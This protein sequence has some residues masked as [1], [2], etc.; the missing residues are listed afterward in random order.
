[1]TD[2]TILKAHSGDYD[3]LI[4]LWEASVRATHE[5]LTEK[6]IEDY[7]LLIYDYYFDA[8]NLYYIRDVNQMQGFIGLNNDFIQ[9]LFIRP[10]LIG[11]GIGT[12]LINF[13]T[14]QHGAT[15]VDVNEQ[16]INAVKFYKSHGF[17]ITQRS[18]KDAA[19]KP[20]PVLS[21]DLRQTIDNC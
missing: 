7:R 11:K 2:S 20:Y 3:E 8:Q 19:G 4:E 21:M 13:A 9:M 15:R 5:F 14:E 17:D 6:D 16:N 1:M 18:E 12:A 10:K